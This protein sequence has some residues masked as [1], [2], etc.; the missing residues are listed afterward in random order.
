MAGPVIH[1]P[2]DSTAEAGNRTG[3]LF[4]ITFVVALGGL[5]FGYDWVV[6][7]GAAKFYEAFFHLRDTVAV[8]ADAGPWERMLADFRSPT[9]W[10][11]SCALLGCL[12]GAL[13]SG[14]LGD[15]FGRRPVLLL[16]AANF[17]VSS[18]G[19]AFSNSPDAF[20]AWRIL[21]GVSIGLASNLSPMYIAEIAPAKRRGMLVA[22][23]QLTIVVGVLLAQI[24]NARI[25]REVPAALAVGNANLTD[26]QLAELAGT[27][28]AT[29]G[30]RLMFGACA[31]PSLCFLA[32]MLVVPESP[33]W[34]VRAG[35]RDKARAVLAKIGGDRYAGEAVAE[36][37]ASLASSQ[38]VR[39]S[40][41]EL[42]DRRVSGLLAIGIGL[43][44]L[45]QWCGINVIFNYAEKIFS[46]AGFTTNTALVNMIGTGVVNL[47]FTL[48][49]LFTVDRWGRK[50]LMLFG[51]ASLTILY[52][53]LGFCFKIH[54]TH[55][56]AVSP[57][58]FLG[59]VLAAIGCYAMSLAPVVWVLISEIFPNRIRGVAMSL[60]VGAL[61]LACFILT[62]TF[63]IMKE[64]LGVSGTFWVYA[65]ICAIGFLAIL[66]L[67]ETKGRSLEQLER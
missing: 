17:L 41:R 19:I 11:Q 1:T 7:G 36:I 50:P 15:R 34:L 53:A 66:R 45:Q 35:K 40:L 29:H 64:K 62:Y 43:A 18:L 21:G 52:V 67:R 26:A 38:G 56:G 30:W 8:A 13:V 5:L 60:A 24:V 51:L 23:N 61:W 55:P 59:L 4:L 28:N 32:G 14:A 44:V 22:I 16:S 47:L 20:I 12:G 54:D 10:A 3:Y 9:G 57:Y 2:N 58:V 42:L 46:A 27:W 63:P 6:I 48:V 49:A 65:G 37:E 31:V 33:R 39:I 25:A